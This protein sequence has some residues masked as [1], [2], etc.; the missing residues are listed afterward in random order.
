MVAGGP[1]LAH[2]GRMR[3]RY[4][5][6]IHGVGLSIGAEAPLDAAHLGRLLALLSRFEPQSFSEHLA[7]S[8]HGGNFYNDLLPVPYDSVTLQRVC[9]HIDQVQQRLKRRRC[10]RTRPPTSSTNAPRWIEAQFL[11]EVV[12]RCGC[13]LLLDVNNAYVSAINHRRDA[14]A[15]ISSLPLDSVGEIHLAGFGEDRDAAGARLLIDTHG[16]AI[17]TAVWALYEATLHMSGP[18]PTLIERDNNIPSLAVLYAEAQRAD[19]RCPHAASGWR[20]R[21]ER[22][23][24]AQDAKAPSGGSAEASASSVGVMNIDWPSLS[25]HVFAQALLDPQQPC[26]PGLRSWN[27]SDPAARFAVHRNNAVSSLVEALADTFPVT[28]ELVGDVFFA[29]MARLFVMGA[30][31][32]SPVLALYG[33]DFPAFVEGFAPARSVPY[34]ADV[35][36]L[37]VQRIRAFHAAD[38]P[39]MSAGDLTR[40]LRDPQ[41]LPASRVEFHPSAAVLISR[42]AIVA[43]WAAHQGAGEIA[44]VDPGHPQ[45]ALVLRQQDEVA[46]IA[47]AK[48]APCSSSI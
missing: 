29:A 16:A 9:D 8:S 14:Q 12:R 33:G 10:W 37:E 25:Q 2:L 47:I 20:K 22:R 35:A 23:R 13:G 11:S 48:A 24:A 4:P 19:V 30:P 18:L 36:R 21:H 17:D 43:L 39:V 41:A 34:L 32:R 31:P 40:H 27:G 6:S 45:S 44:E 3:E 42:F 5:L 1:L 7:W 26:P 38:A 15:F 46:V 28:R